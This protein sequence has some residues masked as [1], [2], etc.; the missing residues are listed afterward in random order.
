MGHLFLTGIYFSLSHTLLYAAY[1]INQV[2][3]VVPQP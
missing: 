3:R 1:L 2:F